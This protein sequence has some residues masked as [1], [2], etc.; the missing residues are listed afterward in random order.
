MFPAIRPTVLRFMTSLSAEAKNL[1]ET[2]IL[3]ASILLRHVNVDD[4]GRYRCV[5]RP[6]SVD[7][8]ANLQEIL[9]NDDS[10]VRS[11][12]YQI[13]ITGRFSLHTAR[14]IRFSS[15]KLLDSVK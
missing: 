2:D 10:S 4:S 9:F 11:L 15:I 12:N 7:P 14:S 6:W 1:N 5:M 8:L 13:E 3:D